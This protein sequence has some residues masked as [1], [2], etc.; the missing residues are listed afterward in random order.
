MTPLVLA[1]LGIDDATGSRRDALSR[2]TEVVYEMRPVQLARLAPAAF[3]LGDDAVALAIVDGASQALAH[4]LAG[5]LDSGIGGPLVLGGS[6]L[7]HQERVAAAVETSFR[8]PRRHRTRR[9][10]RRRRRRRGDARAPPRRGRR[11][12]GG[13]RPDRGVPGGPAPA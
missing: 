11:R 1:Q 9:Q 12:P 4:T 10:G 2:L 3:V 8:A 13:V 5:V 6:V 7:L